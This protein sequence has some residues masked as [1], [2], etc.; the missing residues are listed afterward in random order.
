MDRRLLLYGTILTLLAF[1]F[2]SEIHSASFKIVNKCRRT[3]WPG[4]LSGANTPQL[5][6]TGFSLR[7]G[8]S[9]TVSIPKHWSGR[10]WGRTLCG[11]DSTGKFS[12]TTADCGSGKVECTGSGAKPPATLAEFTLNGDGGLDFYDVSLV[13]GYNLPMLVV[14]R[15]GTGGGCS[16]TGC[17]VDLN[18]ACPSALRVARENGRGT[19]ACRSACETFADPRFCCSEA[20]STPDTCGPSIYSLFFKYACPRAYSYAYDDK[21]STYTCASAD[22]MIIFCPSPYTS[23]KLLGARKDGAQLPLVNKT[24]M[25]MASQHASS[26]G[27]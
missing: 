4:F 2:L 8:K 11:E 9:K 17:L 13:D 19:V 14:P 1:S 26:S 12:C 3:I 15:G 27:R 5:P 16:A 21:T 25:Y 18:G 7:S 6:T 22:Y 10:I 20:Y 24:T 23:Q